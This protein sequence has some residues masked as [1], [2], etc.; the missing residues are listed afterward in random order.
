M[1][2]QIPDTDLLLIH[3]GNHLSG[4][5]QSLLSC[6]LTAAEPPLW[7][8][9]TAAYAQNKGFKV[10]ILDAEC[11]RLSPDE[12]R[13]LAEEINP[14]LIAIPV[15]GHNPSASTQMMPAVRA[16]T[17]A[18]KKNLPAIPVL[19]F[20]GHAAALAEQTLREESADFVCSGE[21]FLTLVSLLQKT[22]S[23]KVPDLWFRD[24]GKIRFSGVSAPLLENLD[25]EIPLPAWNLLPMKQYRAHNWHCFGGLSRSPY[26]SIYTTLGCPYHCPFCCIQAPFKQGEKNSGYKSG[27]NS[28]RF[29][30][31]EKVLAQ[32]DY[33][34][35][36]HGIQNL[37][38]ADEMFVLNPAHVEAICDGLIERDYDLN[39]WAY[40]RIDT[41]RAGMPEKLRKAGFRWLAFGIEA[42][43]ANVR[44][45]VEKRFS[46]DLIRK[47]IDEV[48]QAGI[49]V[50]ANYIFGLPEDN[51]QTM[52]ATLDL[53]MDLNTEFANFYCTM[54]YPGSGLF[55]QARNGNLL[56]KTWE[57]YSQH[58]AETLPLAT[59]NLSA[60]EVLRFRDRAFE[61]YFSNPRYLSRIENTF[62]RET[63]LEIE[64]MTSRKLQ[65]TNA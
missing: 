63:V 61:I 48:R 28:Y 27:V 62:G 50:I 15:Y 23:E 41:V 53:A 57:G 47:T 45:Q 60:S 52:Q 56:P 24:S 10:R 1:K 26:A 37:K 13:E 9:I 20:G 16:V 38:I 32:I 49:Y 29:W 64:K 39:L 40:A 18:L 22:S 58:S 51:L 6:E 5:Y 7:A 12:I 4:S 19:L 8:A 2:P 43:D 44:G 31:P 35:K 14:R 17:Q 21:G 46:E 30:S 25:K 36:E 55:E 33:L 34:F 54:A 3:P 65:R 42:A 59:K 11:L